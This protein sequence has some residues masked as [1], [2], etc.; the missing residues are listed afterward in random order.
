MNAHSCGKYLSATLP[1]VKTTKLYFYHSHRKSASSGPLRNPLTL[2]ST[3][4]A[5]PPLL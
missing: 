1:Q 3:R 2:G 4:V 5:I